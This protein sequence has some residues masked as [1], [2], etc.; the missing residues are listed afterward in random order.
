MAIKPF[1]INVNQKQIDD[2]HE[3]LEKTIMPSQIKSG[4]W[5][6]GPTTEYVSSVVKHILNKY[7]WKKHE[8]EINKYPQFTTEID[9]QEY[10]LHAR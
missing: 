5:S 10:S 8:A 3:R 7:D 1:T 6:Y 2:L 9:G 4:G